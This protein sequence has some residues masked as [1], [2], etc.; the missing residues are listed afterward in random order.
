MSGTI[1]RSHIYIEL[2]IALKALP[3]IAGELLFFAGSVAGF[4]L[5]VFPGF[6]FYTAFLFQTCYMVDYGKTVTAA[7]EASRKIS[8]GY[9]WKMFGIIMAFT[10]IMFLPALM[11]LSLSTSTNNMLVQEFTFYFLLTIM[12]LMQQRL[13]A[14]LYV[15]LEYPKAE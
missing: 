13:T 4:I 5:L 11:L 1:S 9:K 8:Y 2:K 3:I 7:F 12:N 15:S 6:I 14:L 10:L